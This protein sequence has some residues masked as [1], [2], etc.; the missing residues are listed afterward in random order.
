LV[1]RALIFA[2]AVAAAL[3]LGTPPA[4]HA[5]AG[6]TAGSGSA[7]VTTLH[8]VVMPP[9]H[10]SFSAVT[11][12]A[13]QA[14]PAGVSYPPEVNGHWA[15]YA[16][17][18]A[19]GTMTSVTS[20]WVQPRI[21]YSV[22]GYAATWVGLDGF[23]A[24]DN[25]VEQ[26]GTTA[27]SANGL[28]TYYAWYEM[29]QQGA[30][31][32]PVEFSNPVEPGDNMTASVTYAAGNYTLYLRDLTEGWSQTVNEAGTY[33]NSSAEVVLE[34][35]TDGDDYPYPL[36]QFGYV[37]FFGNSIDGQ[38][39]NSASTNTYGITMNDPDGGGD[40]VPSATDAQG[41]FAV[42]YGA[43]NTFGGAPL[44][45]DD[46]SVG[47][48]GLYL[49][50]PSATGG[51]APTSYLGQDAWTDPV[52]TA[53]PGGGF[54]TAFEGSTPAGARLM[55]SGT[56]FTFNTQLGMA[57]Q[58]HPAIAAAANGTWEVAFQANTGE[59]YEYTPQTGGVPLGYSMAAGTSPS[60]TAMP[61]GFEIAFQDS[62]GTL[63]ELG[64]SGA[65][66]TG[67][68]MAAS[69]SPAIAG[70]V[71][72]N[73]SIVAFQSRAGYYCSI[74]LIAGICP[75]TYP[76]AAG[77]S[78]GITTLAG[79]GYEAAFQASNGLLWEV[80]TYD[81]FNTELGMKGGTSPTITASAST[82]FEVAFQANT[83]QLWLQ[84]LAHGGRNQNVNITLDPSITG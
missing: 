48:G 39:L 42:T 54:E 29:Y 32:P 19:A 8:D 69:T 43:S 59:L 51:T 15:G 45:A 38:A 4:A 47:E 6:Q 5:V 52:V 82:V 41:D 10:A 62:D 44:I 53:L 80:G 60:I 74:N 79:G 21:D 17:T 33:A 73:G 71:S 75:T 81:N 55:V 56:S 61:G 35:P 26:I 7:R 58:T 66:A 68:A 70:P 40:A 22:G 72:G 20:N 77:T 46:S 18:G 49:T 67:I 3:A 30:N 57:L 1:R 34:T 16:V 2:A 83:G 63:W 14:H 50:T 84:D 64:P 36:T 12:E 76:M 37:D 25:T 31:T 9:L 13:P 27:E 23:N 24:G 65:W 28:P 11:Q 78:P